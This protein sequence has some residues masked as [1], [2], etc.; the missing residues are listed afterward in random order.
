MA[1]SINVNLQPWIPP[2]TSVGAYPKSNW[3]YS[4]RDSPSGEPLG[5][6]TKTVTT[7]SSGIA[8]FTGLATNTEYWAVADVGGTYKYVGFST[9][10]PSGGARV[11][12]ANDWTA[13]QTF[14]GGSSA[15]REMGQPGIIAPS[16]YTGFAG[17][18]WTANQCRVSRFVPSR[19]LTV[20]KIAFSVTSADAANPAT[21]VGI[22]D[23]SG[24]KIV[25]S[26]AAT[27][28][29]N[30]TGVKAV[31]IAATNLEAGTV[32]Y[33]AI[34][35]AGAPTISCASLTSANVA[36]LFGATVPNVIGGTLTASHPLPS[37]IASVGGGTAP[38]LLAVRES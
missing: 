32:Y 25:A 38:P 5:S 10:D 35:C 6:A 27:G 15:G 12:G 28:I 23:A 21:D 13:S 31:T 4:Q 1:T 14:S 16:Q 3:P 20:T 26:T 7:S 37:S 33:A 34:S 11:N 29:V 18:V 2:S 36:E 9:F 8:A 22:Y 24:A 19:D 17:S 30:S